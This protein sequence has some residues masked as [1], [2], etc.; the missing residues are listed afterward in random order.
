MVNG[1]FI[2]TPRPLHS[3]L[4]NDTAKKL[5]RHS[6]SAITSDQDLME[7][8]QTWVM[9]RRSGNTCSIIQTHTLGGFGGFFR[10]CICTAYIRILHVPVVNVFYSVYCSYF[11][12]VQ[13]YFPAFHACVSE[14]RAKSIMCSYNAVNGV[15]SCANGLFQNTAVRDEWGFDGYIVSAV[16]A[17]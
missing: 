12:S 15:P 3:D 9:L 10:T 14:G 11:L 1:T 16:Y 2:A 17:V 6:F 5:D 13:T 4:E 7:V 8:R